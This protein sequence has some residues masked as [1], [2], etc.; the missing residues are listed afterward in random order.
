MDLAS[1]LLELRSEIECSGGEMGQDLFGEV[2]CELAGS[3]LDW[4][5]PQKALIRWVARRRRIDLL[6]RQATRSHKSLDAVGDVIDSASQP[7]KNLEN[8]QDRERVHAALEGLKPKYRDVV[9]LVYL[10]RLDELEVA[11]IL[12]VPR[13]TVRTR[14]RRAIKQ[15]RHWFNQ[16]SSNK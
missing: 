13:E 4:S 1:Q 15:L 3:D 8:A 16:P 2:A 12:G 11:R 6:R 9:Q 10:D 7:S 5:C 14:L